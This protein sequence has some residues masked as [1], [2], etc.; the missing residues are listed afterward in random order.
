MRFGKRI[1][2]TPTLLQMES[3]EC[4][5]AALGIILS[6][7]GLFMPLEQ[8]RSEC[9]VNRD[10]SKAS[11]MLKAARRFGMEAKG[12]NITLND[13]L[14]ATIPLI[15]HWNFNHFLVLE[16][17]KGGRAYL[18][19][20]AQGH[21]TA[22]MEEFANSFTGVALFIAPGPKFKKGGK[23]YSVAK[24]VVKKLTME[25]AALIAVMIV[26]LL[27]IVP[28]L[29]SPVFDQ[30]FIDEILSGKHRGWL[31]NLMLAMGISF[32]LTGSLS[33]LRAW[34]LTKWQTK[35]T[36]G[37]SSRFIWH[38]LRLPASFFQQRFSGEI[39]MR[40]DFN[41]AIA[42][43]FTGE[44]ATVVLD[45]FVAF[46]Y[47]ALLLQY[48]PKLTAI[49][50]LFCAIN[51]AV[52]SFSRKKLIEMSMRLQQEDGKA[53]GTAVGGIQ[54]I[55]TLKAN[56]NEADFFA[57]WAGYSAKSN[58]SMQEISVASE[59]MSLAPAFLNAVNTALIMIVGGFEIMDGVM[60][61]GVFIAFRGL[62]DSFQ[63]P[64]GKLIGLAQSLQNTEMQMQKLNDVLKY[65]IDR[66][67]YPDKLPAAIDVDRLTGL[68]ELVNVSFGYSPL[69][70]P[71]IENFNLTLKPGRWVALVGGS[72]SG[73]STVARIVSGLYHEW[74]GKILFD[75][76]ERKDIPKEVL[77]NSIACVD[78]E[79]YLFS[80]SIRENLSLF[81]PSVPDADILQGAKDAVIYDDIIA[82]EGGFD[83]M[84]N[85][86]GV[87]FSG[88][89][90]QRLEIARALTADPS[91][92][93]FDEATSALD[94][95]TEELLM[96]NIR[97]RGCACLMVAHRL[98]AFRDC[99]EIIVLE[100]GK[101]VQ[102]GTHN[103]MIAVDGP[104]RR[105]VS[106]QL[107]PGKE[108]E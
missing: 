53:M 28:G 56:G 47:L 80:G 6:Y 103:E 93:I 48:S 39:A 91:I 4:G 66:V 36:L 49:G 54:V 13:L 105:L 61:A 90:R 2:K 57:K 98:S 59:L 35:L 40:V 17:F 7:Y 51:I 97:R 60:S 27:S 85:E 11:N 87:N 29:A 21:R 63:S 18:N 106:G 104:Y 68:V 67:N 69:D 20:P 46:F 45:L 1:R 50:V 44:A 89:Q 34:C 73:K 84:I 33:M 12:Y 82:A 10:G 94:P 96:T 86:G 58:N 79:I 99:D 32:F 100:Y 74:S 83:H 25:K 19:D 81:D 102:R 78:Q 64:V 52:M 42:G 31:M 38:V 16:G 23:K 65:N 75:G 92:L 70:S 107:A 72:G 26:G 76:R 30:V 15:I 9:G 55:E 71:L 41:E 14:G 43:V 8:L 37:D 5:A 108:E 3:V 22:S 88:G 77:V 24:D 101:V 95:V 62:M